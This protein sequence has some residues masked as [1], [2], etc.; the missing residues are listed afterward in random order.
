MAAVPHRIEIYSS[1][2]V[3]L[4]ILD[5]ARNIRYEQKLNDSS[6]F[7]FSLDFRDP[8]A[9]EANL[10]GGQNYIKYFRGTQLQFSGEMVRWDVSL[11]ETSETINVVCADWVWILKDR[12][13][14]ASDVHTAQNEG[15]IL[16]DL[17]TD[18]QALSDGDL[19]ITFGVN[20][21][22][23]I[24]DRTYEDKNLR[25]AF[26]QMSNIINGVDFEITPDRVLNIYD[27]KGVDRSSSHVFEFGVN[28]ESLGHSRDWTGLANDLRGYGNDALVVERDDASSQSTYGRRMQT[29]SFP[30]V[31]VQTTLEG[32]LDDI[33]RTGS[34][35]NTEYSCALLPGSEPLFGTYELGDTVTIKVNEGFILINQAVRIY[36]WSVSVDDDWKES[37]S[38]LISTTT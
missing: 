12:H 18:T 8:K 28:L 20:L 3:L 32:H 34:V 24:R 7:S 13:T 9:T 27:K 31:S 4:A 15:E 21:A 14:V 22:T 37:I 10:Q 6:S 17:I 26:I 33:L 36:G 5:K 35:P 29:P 11:D 1:S 30:D 38:L 23:S 2:D 16:Q 19:G 25:D